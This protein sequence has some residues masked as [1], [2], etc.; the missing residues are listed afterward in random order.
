MEAGARSLFASIQRFRA[1]PDYLQ[2]WPGHGAGSA[3]G[4]A[5]G[6]VP[7]TTLGYEKIANWALAPQSE[8]DFVRHVLEG[9]PEP[10][11]YFAD[12]KRINRA[13]PPPLGA[14]VSPRR[15]NAKE[16]VDILESGALVV[17]T[18][19]AKDFAA[20][21]VPGTINIPLGR[22]FTN[23]AGSLIPFD[24]DFYLIID[25]SD[26]LRVA[27]AQRNLAMI[28][29]DHLVGYFGTDAIDAFTA[30]GGATETIRQMKL[31][32]LASPP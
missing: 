30:N 31:S 27:E 28:G 15:L 21:L 16:L 5:L 14:L 1:Y 11:K 8:D 20:R 17:D 24:R 10:P 12:M 19:A 4:K 18:R 7:S 6:A 23:W 13:G 22:S 32:E 9:Q 2:L 25:D 3:C 26:T 29:L